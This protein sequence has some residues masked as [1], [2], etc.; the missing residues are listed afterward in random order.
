MTIDDFA[1]TSLAVPVL[2]PAKRFNYFISWKTK[3][4][5]SMRYFWF[6]KMMRNASPINSAKAI[7][8]SYANPC[9]HIQMKDING[10]QH[11]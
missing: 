6:E 11:S 8:V 3:D 5:K 7:R 4:T 10:C 1:M 9:I 2:F